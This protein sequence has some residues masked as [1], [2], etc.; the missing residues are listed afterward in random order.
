ML[1]QQEGKRLISIYPT[2]LSR[3]GL[4][5]VA[6][7]RIFGYRI[8]IHERSEVSSEENATNSTWNSEASMKDAEAKEAD[9]DK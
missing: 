2:D 6:K 8:D 3:L 7:L 9:T 1:Y 5:L 4:L